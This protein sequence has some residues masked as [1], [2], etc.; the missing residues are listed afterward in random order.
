MALDLENAQ[1]S[2][3]VVGGAGS[4]GGRGLRALA[5]QGWR[6]TGSASWRSSVP[7]GEFTCFT[8]R[9]ATFFMAGEQVVQASVRQQR[10][11]CVGAR[12]TI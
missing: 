3:C 6:L 1:K 10:G 7:L 5:V 9:S 2:A 4:S 11:Y 8:S 12:I